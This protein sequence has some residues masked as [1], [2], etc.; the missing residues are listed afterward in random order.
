MFIIGR[1]RRDFRGVSR[2]PGFI[3]VRGQDAELCFMLDKTRFRLEVGQGGELGEK[4]DC[5]SGRVSRPKG[6]EKV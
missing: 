4:L 3:H 5:G 2:C 1:V 6:K